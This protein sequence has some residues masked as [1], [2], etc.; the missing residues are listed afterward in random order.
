MPSVLMLGSVG[1][2]SMADTKKCRCISTK[3]GKRPLCFVGKSK[4][5]PSG[6]TFVKGTCSR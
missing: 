4:K 2:A 5:H 3:R 6:W 1:D